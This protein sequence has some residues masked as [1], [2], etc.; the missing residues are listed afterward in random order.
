MSSISDTKNCYWQNH[1]DAKSYFEALD[2][3]ILPIAKSHALNEEE[4]NT[5]E[6]ILSVLCQARVKK[7]L[8]DISSLKLLKEL[9][10]KNLVIEDKD[11]FYIKNE[12]KDLLR[13]FACL[14][15]P[16]FQKERVVKEKTYSTS[17]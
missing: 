17:F 10:E 12:S 13:F 3:D 14:I 16:L 8:I 9:E 2:N 7:S 6:N 11:Y 5:K 4:Q 15:D 1:K